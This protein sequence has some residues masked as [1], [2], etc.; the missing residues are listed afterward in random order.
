MA[1]DGVGGGTVRPLVT[2]E[3]AAATPAGAVDAGVAA[4]LYALS[5]SGGATAAAMGLSAPRNLGDVEALFAEIAAVLDRTV[6][7]AA[8]QSDLAATESARSGLLSLSALIGNAAA[9]AAIMTATKSAITALETM[10]T[11]LQGEVE[12]LEK[13][14]EA[15]E[16]ER[17]GLSTDTAGYLSTME[18]E[19]AAIAERDALIEAE[20]AKDEPDQDAID[21]WEAANETSQGLI[22]DAG[23]DLIVASAR[24]TEIDRTDLPAVRAD[25]ELKERTIG[26]NDE[27]ISGYTA[28]YNTAKAAYSIANGVVSVG[29]LLSTGTETADEEGGE[30][31]LDALIEAAVENAQL[32]ERQIALRDALREK[33]LE[34]GLATEA[35]G[36]VAGI[37]TQLVAG[38][39]VALAGLERLRGDAALFSDKVGAP[40]VDAAGRMKVGL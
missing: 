4:A 25:I 39:A 35:A 36:R 19:R 14:E 15:L 23:D 32:S 20:Q 26:Q 10:N 33:L 22:D 12:T 27:L 31:D 24:I 2:G 38:I 3:A 17:E 5:F 37:G 21:A 7:D 28:D 9:A 29:S 6:G 40:P 13:Q 11:T 16:T 18:T 1:I 30:I 34:G 8:A